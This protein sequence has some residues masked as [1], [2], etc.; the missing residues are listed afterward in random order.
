MA[1]IPQ[2]LIEA[3]FHRG[4][5]RATSGQLSDGQVAVGGAAGRHRIH[6]QGDIGAAAEQPQHSL[7]DADMSLYAA[8]QPMASADPG[9]GGCHCRLPQ[10]AEAEFGQHGGTALQRL[11]LGHSRPQLVRI[12]FQPDNRQT[13]RLGPLYQ[14]C[15]IGNQ[16]GALL[17]EPCQLALNIDDQQACGRGGQHDGSL[18]QIS[19]WR[20]VDG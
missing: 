15:A 20:P 7:V 11:Q 10:R 8:H 18:G 1:A 3:H 14:P 5:P 16:G 4:E 13:Q 19:V 6:H 2:Q 17:D 9:E 12:L